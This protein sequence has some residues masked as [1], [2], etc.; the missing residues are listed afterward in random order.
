M[1]GAKRMMASLVI[2]ACAL[3]LGGCAIAPAT[4]GAPDPGLRGQWVLAGG[5][6]T[7]G[8]LNLLGQHITLTVSKSSV[9]T[10]RSSCSNYTATIYG[11]PRQ[12]WITPTAPATY[13][14]ATADQNVLQLEYLGDLQRVRQS[15]VTPGSLILTAQGV[16]L[17]FVRA[18][19]LRVNDLLNKTWRLAT[20]ATINLHSPFAFSPETGGSLQF[21]EPDVIEARTQ[22]LSLSADYRQV[23]DEL[24]TNDV[25]LFASLPCDGTG[26][27][28]AADFTR[29]FENG[30]TFALTRNSLALTSSRA[31]VALGFDEVGAP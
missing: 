29:V 28:A 25:R 7:F 8:T 27:Q 31:G 23:G 21:L 18:T 30:F 9:S 5:T 20:S 15:V 13:T 6:D 2:A 4:D 14:C 19:P 3:A 16:E 11:S 1:R 22:C 12:L 10:G 17:R 26:T 24:V